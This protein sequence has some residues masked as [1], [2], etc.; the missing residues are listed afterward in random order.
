MRIEYIEHGSNEKLGIVE[1]ADIKET[2][3]PQKNN[4]HSVFINKHFT[5]RSNQLAWEIARVEI[6]N[7]LASIYLIRV[8]DQ[9]LSFGAYAHSR[10]KKRGSAFITK[11]SIVDVDFG[12]HA[13]VSD[14]KDDTGPN[15]KFAG[16]LLP[17]EL[18]KRRP[19]IVLDVNSSRDLIQILPLTTAK[20]SQY[21][22][23][24]IRLSASSLSHLEARYKDDPSY[25]MLGMIQ[26]VSSH[27]AFPARLAGGDIRYGDRSK[28]GIPDRQN[29]EA[30]LASRYSASSKLATENLEKR[31]R[32]RQTENT[33]LNQKYNA[34]DAE[35]NLIEQENTAL[36]LDIAVLEKRNARSEELIRE[37]GG[38]LFDCHDSDFEQ[39]MVSMSTL[40]K[41]L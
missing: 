15:K 22:K 37:I 41:G 16:S 24:C 20:E 29:I 23:S 35:K 6:G 2:V 10:S 13:L 32:D 4:S 40:T 7:S 31:L 28:I 19:C 36:N 12:H 5:S 17:K 14:L 18:H 8:V 25:A 39:L 11:H 34:L 9:T 3:L 27:R 26:S 33:S 1:K 21:D 30:M 38:K